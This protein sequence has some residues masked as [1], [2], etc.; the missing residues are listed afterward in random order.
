MTLAPL[1]IAYFNFY[2][3]KNI[4]SQFLAHR[5]G[6]VAIGMDDWKDSFVSFQRLGLVIIFAFEYLVFEVIFLLMKF[7]EQDIIYYHIVECFICLL[8]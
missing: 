7:L 5:L 4:L 1:S 6:K 3:L 2:F 8:E